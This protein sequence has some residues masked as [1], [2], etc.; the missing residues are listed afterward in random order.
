MSNQTL[1]AVAPAIA[2]YLGW[3]WSDRKHDL[4]LRLAGQPKGTHLQ[5]PAEPAAIHQY[6]QQLHQRWPH[7]KL[8]VCLEAS[9]SA[10]LPIFSAYLDWLLVYA[11]N[12]KTLARYRE[13]FRPSG[14]KDDPSDCSLLADLPIT[15]PDQ[16]EPWQPLDSQTQELA[17]L[18][19]YRRGEV[20][21]R[22][23]LANQLKALLKTYFPQALE[24]LNDNTTT[25]LASAWVRRWSTLPALQATSPRDIRRF[26]RAQGCHLTA[27]LQ[28]LI[29]HRTQ[30]QPVSTQPQWIAPQAFQAQRL[31]A[32]LAALHPTI[33]AYDQLIADKYSL[34]PA[35]PLIQT[36]PGA[37]AALEPRLAALLSADPTRYQNHLELATLTGIAPM[38]RQSGK[39]QIVRRRRARP[40]F[41]HQTLVEFAKSS[42]GQ[43]PWAAQFCHHK[44]QQGWKYYRIIRAL[45]YKWIRIIHALQR[46]GQPYDEAKYQTA[47]KKNHSPHALQQD[48]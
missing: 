21:R 7:Q 13:T 8:V 45:A 46:T 32:Q 40:R 25:P 20:D 42:I 6:L 47:L 29:A 36:L 48:N 41:A 19:E 1:S 2:A 18:T 17:L 11:I 10:L 30:A 16:L 22:T 35:R 3:D 9:R 27:R 37:G 5:L 26:Y 23:G 43:C 39:T 28:E 38:R 33:A 15:H 24:W 44:Q 4:C 34:H 14:G 31:A 12:P